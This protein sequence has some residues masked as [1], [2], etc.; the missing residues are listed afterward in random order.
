MLAWTSLSR[1]AVHRVLLILLVP[2]LASAQTRAIRLR[3]A[4]EIAVRQN[5]SLQA[6]IADV[7]VAEGNV[8]TARGLDDLSLDGTG[9]WTENRIPGSTYLPTEF[10]DLNGSLALT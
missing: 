4:I 6:A 5:P 9:N 8:E 7:A 1:L 10:D 2:S 3:D